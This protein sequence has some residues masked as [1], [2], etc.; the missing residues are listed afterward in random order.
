M[1]DRY[2]HC[3]ERFSENDN[4]SLYHGTSLDTMPK[5]LEVVDDKACF[6]LDA[7]DEGGGVPTFEELELIKNHSIKN[8]TIVVDD[9]PVYF[10]DKKE[11]LENLILTINNKYKIDYVPVYFGIAPDYTTHRIINDYQLLAYVE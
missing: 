8:H 6:W 9:I 10:S 2:N 3:L 7:H 4:V 1:E 11:E 5:M